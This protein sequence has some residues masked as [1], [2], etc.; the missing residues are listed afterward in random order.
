LTLVLLVTA[1]CARSTDD[2]GTSAAGSLESTPS[3]GRSAAPALRFAADK[4]YEYEVAL[5][6]GVEMVGGDQLVDVDVSGR[7]VLTAAD[8]T[9]GR[10]S[11]WSVRLRP[12][13]AS[14]RHASEESM[15]ELTHELEVGF[16]VVR[17]GAALSVH[18]PS[19]ASQFAWNLAKTLASM[20]QLGSESEAAAGVWQ[21]GEEDVTGKYT[22][23]YKALKD[24]GAYSK[25]KLSY[26]GELIQARDQGGFNVSLQPEVVESDGVLKFDQ[27]TLSSVR[28]REVL[29]SSFPG[30]GHAL[31]RTGIT[32]ELEQTAPAH[33]AENFKS[34]AAKW[35][36]APA[37]VA[38][39]GAATAFDHSKIGEFTFESASQAL[40]RLTQGK[41]ALLSTNTDQESSA[42]RTAREARIAEH[43]R[44]F[45]ALTAIIRSEPGAAAKAERMLREAPAHPLYL[46]DALASAESDQAQAIVLELA[47]DASLASAVRS[48]ARS[49]AVR[50]TAPSAQTV[51]T[52]RSW[53]DQPE[54]DIYALYGLGTM[55][56][57]LRDSGNAALAA[58]AVQPLAARLRA[59]RSPAD[60]VHA[61]RGIAN[62]GDSALFDLVL[63]FLTDSDTELRGAAAQALRLMKHPGVDEKL[64]SVAEV[65]TD[66]SVQLALLGAI[67]PRPASSALCQA[68]LRLAQSAAEAQVRFRAVRLLESWA[69]K[70]AELSAALAQ[71]AVEDLSDDVRAIAKGALNQR[72]AAQ[73]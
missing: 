51:S 20:L 73:P 64:R 26:A 2:S 49:A 62:S 17:E 18:M 1:A 68:V 66:G 8:D 71:I 52:L 15:T 31:A 50:I 69:P 53:L 54:L 5:S 39:D 67:Q 47:E 72:P 42:E 61:L 38:T 4:R 45:T 30:G 35:P 37:A 46:L 6:S 44:A 29:R 43:N 57:L 23:E 41:A 11:A 48:R 24:T 21:R 19:G 16:V 55:A 59:A 7:L 14:S 65:E 33:P 9:D 22:A 13:K 3:A 36:D 63:P 58:S 10:R 12:G 70:T 25:K 40:E 60:R 32:L 34:L 27:G 56:R 28:Y